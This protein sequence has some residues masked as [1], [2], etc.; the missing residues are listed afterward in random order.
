MWCWIIIDRCSC[1]FC[2]CS[3]SEL[4]RHIA[5]VQVTND[6]FLALMQGHQIFSK[7]EVPHLSHGSK[8]CVSTLTPLKHHNY[9]LMLMVAGV[10][11]R[12]GKWP[13][14]FNISSLAAD[15]SLVIEI[16]LKTNG[17]NA[18]HTSTLQIMNILEASYIAVQTYKQM[19]NAQSEQF[20]KWPLYFKQSNLLCCPALIPMF[21]FLNAWQW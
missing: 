2:N 8:A 4:S 21:V 14:L 11:V 5:S 1:C 15:N 19:L 18:R 3:K 17:K 20:L 13:A 6:T 10:M 16:Y 12:C 9:G 7:A